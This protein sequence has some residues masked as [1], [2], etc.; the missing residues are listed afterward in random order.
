[1][2]I[3]LEPNIAEIGPRQQL[4]FRVAVN[5]AALLDDSNE[6]FLAIGG[7]EEPPDGFLIQVLREK[8]MTSGQDATYHLNGGGRKRNLGIMTENH[9]H[10]GNMPVTRGFVGAHSPR[11]F[12][13]MAGVR[14]GIAAP[15]S[16]RP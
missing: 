15:H 9:L 2:G 14:R 10:L 16:N 12:R 6:G 13:M 11:P 3:L 4:G 1:M 8:H 5:P 7:A